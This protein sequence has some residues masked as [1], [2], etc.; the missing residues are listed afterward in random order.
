MY[1]PPPVLPREGAARRRG[2]L[3]VRGPGSLAAR[4][5]PCGTCPSVPGADR[6]VS[7]QGE[8]GEDGAARVPCP[9][10]RSAPA[11]ACSLSG[12]L[13]AVRSPGF[14]P[15]LSTHSCLPL[16]PHLICSA[17]KTQR[18]SRLCLLSSHTCGEDLGLPLLPPRPRLMLWGSRSQRYGQSWPRWHCVCHLSFCGPAGSGRWCSP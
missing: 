17:K 1:P 8:G 18:G 12:S 13:P 10:P 15:Y 9:L 5:L 3:R 7:R 11:T 16:P 6:C 2:G 4:P 14:T